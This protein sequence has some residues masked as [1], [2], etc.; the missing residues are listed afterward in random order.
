MQPPKSMRIERKDARA[1]QFYAVLFTVL[2]VLGGLGLIWVD[3]VIAKVSMLV[4]AALAY[5]SIRANLGFSRAIEHVDDRVLVHPLWTTKVQTLQGLTELVIR[6]AIPRDSK[7]ARLIAD[8]FTLRFPEGPVLVQTSAYPEAKELVASLLQEVCGDVAFP[9][10]LG[11]SAMQHWTGSPEGP[12]LGVAAS[13][14][15]V[16]GTL[17]TIF[18]YGAKD[19]DK[20]LVD[21]ELA[22]SLAAFKLLC[23]KKQV[24]HEV[25]EPSQT[26]MGGLQFL[27]ASMVAGIGAK[28]VRS[29]LLLTTW[30]RRLLKVRV[31]DAP[32][33]EI[34]GA[35]ATLEAFLAVNGS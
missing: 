26:K 19:I 30:Q 8:H 22:S 2:P 17:L 31:A 12:S 13:Y 4:C 6:L 21:E 11:D 10:E 25:T 33:G 29:Q 5:Q 32:K 14:R 27:S 34:A 28:A 23:Q 3:G 15:H 18:V 1:T 9:L 24:P 20:G 7:P 35:E 16:D